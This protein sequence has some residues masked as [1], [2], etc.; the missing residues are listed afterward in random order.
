[1][2]RA[3]MW[4]PETTVTGETIAR[5]STCGA[6]ATWALATSPCGESEPRTKRRREPKFRRVAPE[7]RAE[8]VRRAGEMRA[9]GASYR[10][11]ADALGVYPQLAWTYVQAYERRAAA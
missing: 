11:I 8:R 4:T 3:H 6:L 5:C 2:T 7:V 9:A 10:E 1:M